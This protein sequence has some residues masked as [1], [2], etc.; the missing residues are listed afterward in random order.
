MNGSLVV[1][2][3]PTAERTLA[4][5]VDARSA[6]LSAKRVPPGRYGVNRRTGKPFIGTAK[7]TLELRAGTYWFGRDPRLTGRLVVG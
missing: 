2:A 5:K 6:S 3:A 1:V 7:W 4:A